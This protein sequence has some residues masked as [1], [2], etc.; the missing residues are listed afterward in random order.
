M[1]CSKCERH[2][3]FKN[4]LCV[5]CNRQRRAE[6]PI[7]QNC[8]TSAAVRLSQQLCENC[9]RDR[10]VRAGYQSKSKHCPLIH[11]PEVIVTVPCVRGHCHT[12]DELA[13]IF[14][15]SSETIRQIER[16]AL[17][18]MAKDPVLRQFAIDQ[19]I[20]SEEGEAA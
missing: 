4:G 9:W 16:K 6:R 17:A 3:R 7:C 18:L 20:I 13:A 15:T 10:N 14:G 11:L 19:E 1:K 5:V 8:H 2:A 12:L